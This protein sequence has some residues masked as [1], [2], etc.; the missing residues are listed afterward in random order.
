MIA[1]L[2]VHAVPIGV[3]ANL[4]TNAKATSNVATTIVQQSL[5]TIKKPDAAMTTALNGWTWEME[6]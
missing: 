3:T 5:D 4:T 2:E 6:F 1:V